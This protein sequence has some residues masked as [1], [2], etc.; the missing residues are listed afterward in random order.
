MIPSDESL[1]ERGLIEFDGFYCTLTVG[2]D[3]GVS[4]VTATSIQFP[5]V[6]CFALFI[7]KCLLAREKVGAFSAPDFAIIRCALHGENTYSLG[8]IVARRLHFN[9]SKGKI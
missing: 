9:G 8:A 5:D 3:R 1:V 4:S 2:D 6:R 7:A